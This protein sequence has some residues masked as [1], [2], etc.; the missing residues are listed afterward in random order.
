MSR[1]GRGRGEEGSPKDEPQGNPRDLHPTSDIRFV[2]IE[3]AKL[4]E[5]V[6]TLVADVG[7]VGP[8]FEKAAE[9][10]SKDLK[11]RLAELKSEGKET[12]GSIKKIENDMSFFKGA[13]WVLGGIFA[14]FLVIT[15]VVLREVLTK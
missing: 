3:V 11:E 2:M 10:L 14:L 1:L 13:V 9:A 15:G 7:K 6:D 5:R 4:S 8:N 12:T